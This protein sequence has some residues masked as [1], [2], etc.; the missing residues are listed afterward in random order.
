MLEDLAGLGDLMSVVVM[1]SVLFLACLVTAGWRG[2][3]P[4][5]VAAAAGLTEPVL[6]PLIGQTHMG[7]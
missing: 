1:T 3:V 6:K 7:R 2:A 4:V 5:A